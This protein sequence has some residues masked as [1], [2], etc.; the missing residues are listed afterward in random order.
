[1]P[2][3]GGDG[4]DCAAVFAEHVGEEGLEGDEVGECVDAESSGVESVEWWDVEGKGT[5]CSTSSVVVSR[6]DFLWTMPALLMR[7]VGGPSWMY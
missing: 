7:I 5:Y 1:M 4:D 6:M 3:D 2:E